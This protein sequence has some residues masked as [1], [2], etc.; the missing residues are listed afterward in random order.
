MFILD[1]PIGA[2]E[3]KE[4]FKANTKTGAN[5]K[6]LEKIVAAHS[7]Q[8]L[9]VP[10]LRE[11]DGYTEVWL[12]DLF[13][14]RDA[15]LVITG[16]RAKGAKCRP[17]AAKTVIL[18]EYGGGGDYE[19]MLFNLSKPDTP[20]GLHGDENKVKP[21]FSFKKIDLGSGATPGGLRTEV[22]SG[23]KDCNF[24]FEAEYRDAEG[25]HVQDIRN[26]K[27]RFDVRGIPANPE[28]V[29]VVTLEGIKDCGADP[30]PM[31]PCPNLPFKTGR[32]SIF[33]D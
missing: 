12:I 10:A 1:R 4:L 15:S 18:F 27:G 17:A 9:R 20:L 22:S 7:G 33:G 28:Q 14:D 25:A 5:F 31:I 16:V 29:F 2:E 21:Y 3:R 26:D 30:G 19:G 6:D 13:S 23:I 32:W 11:A 24:I 8:E